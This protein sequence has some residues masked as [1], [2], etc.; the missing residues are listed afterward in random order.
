MTIGAFLEEHL[1]E[2][3]VMVVLLAAS[4]FF[5]GTE[6]AL[7]NLTKGQILHLRGTG[8][9]GRIVAILMDSPHKTLHVLLLGN[10]VVN[11]SYAALCAAVV[12]DLPH[13]MAPWLAVVISLIP[14]LVLILVGEVMPKMLA[15]SLGERWALPAGSVVAIISKILAGPLWTLDQTLIRPLVRVLAGSNSERTEITGEE[16]ASVLDLSA[17][18]GII[19][20]D[21]NALLQEVFELSDLRVRDIMV[22]RVDMVA[23]DVDAP[24]EGLIELFNT[25]R[26][27]RIPVYK[28]DM[29]HILG[30]IHAKRV[31]LRPQEPLGNLVTP[32]VFAPEAGNIERLLLQFR[33]RR[34][35]T[36]I[37]VDEY[38]GTAGIVALQ[39]VL[40]EIVG[41]ISE[42]GDA[43]HAEAV[44]EIEDGTYL[45]QANL[46]IH[47]WADAFK[48]DLSGRRISTIGGFVTSLL[49]RIPQVGDVANYRNLRFTV[50][51][52]RRRRVGSLKLELREADA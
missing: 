38:G 15:Y 13:G 10:L 19:G 29:D 42:P 40:E 2:F 36:A 7:F 11:V 39:D 43:G 48:M 49:G 47:E 5:S 18:R 21:A 44:M 4:G 8:R 50:E 23:Y 46:A 34:A 16:L 33:V 9:T 22:P 37:T 51:S 45:I 26:L 31:L 25:T 24:R 6:T 12:M 20:H 14:L 41:D 27:R 52:V 32:V 17:K 35:Q 3:G 28:N 30:V 1:I